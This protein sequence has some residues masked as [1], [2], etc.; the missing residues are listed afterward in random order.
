[1]KC[2]DR[3]MC[4][5]IHKLFRVGR[6]RRGGGDWRLPVMSYGSVTSCLKGRQQNGS[7]ATLQEL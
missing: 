3:G 5:M 1:M 6:E 4:E 2:S 7:G